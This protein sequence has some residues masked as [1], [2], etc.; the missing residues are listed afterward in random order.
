MK[1][2]SMEMEQTAEGGDQELRV[3]LNLLTFFYFEKI[4]DFLKL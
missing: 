1:S 3:F 4:L 2:L